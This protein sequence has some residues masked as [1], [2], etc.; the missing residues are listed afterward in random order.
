[1]N[2]QSVVIGHIL[3]SLDVLSESFPLYV[4][5]AM[6]KGGR[7][8]YHKTNGPATYPMYFFYNKKGPWA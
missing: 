5:P 4:V 7:S 8:Y 6:T 2:Y 1:M 3:P